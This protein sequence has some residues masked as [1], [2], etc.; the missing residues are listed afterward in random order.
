M[1]ALPLR[2]R[3]VGRDFQPI[4]DTSADLLRVPE[5]DDA[6]WAATAAPIDT[7]R[8]DPVFY[9]WLDT[10]NDGRVRS[11]ELRAA[12]RWTAGL[13]QDPSG[14]DQKSDVVRAAALKAD[15]PDTATLKV[16]ISRV[17]AEKGGSG[18]ASLANVR[19]VL[20]DELAKG[21]SAAGKILPAAAGDD[22]ELRE[23][24]EHVIEVTGGTPHPAG[25]PAVGQP[26]LDRFLAEAK[27]WL[28]WNEKGKLGPDGSSDVLP[29]GAG[30]GA[31][32]AA[33]D[34][35]AAKLA[36]Y[37][38]LCDAIALDAALADKARVDPTGTDL[39]DVG[40]ATALLERAPIA[41][42]RADGV[43]DLDGVVNPAWRARVEALRAAA[44]APAQLTRASFAALSAR[45]DAWRAHTASPPPAK[46]GERGEVVATEHSSDP[47]LV[48]RATALLEEATR[49]AGSVDG[50]KLLEKLCLFQANLLEFA[51][52]LVCMSVL[53]DPNAKA[54][55]E[56][57]RLVLDGKE[58]DMSF[59]VTDAGRAERFGGMSP[60]FL[61][62]VMVGEKGGAWTEQIVVPVTAG[63]RGYVTDGTWGVFFPV[64]GGEWHAQVRKIAVNPI[65]IYEALVAPFRRISD[66]MQSAADKAAGEQTSAMAGKVDA[67]GASAGS[68]VAGSAQSAVTTGEAR[69]LVAAEA[70][71]NPPPAAPPA[72]AAPA[73]PAA[74]PPPGGGMA[75]QL[76]LLL[77]G[78]GVAFAA[79][80]TALGYV[81]GLF[82]Q[83]A[84]AIAGAV[85]GL[86]ILNS[87]PAAAFT[88]I[89]V[90]SFPVA[91]L[92]M[93]LGVVLV[94]FLIYAIPVS[95]ATWLRLRRR[96]L[97]T[98]LEGSG[99]AMNRRMFLDRNLAVQLT[100]KP[101][102]PLTEIA[103][104]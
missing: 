19:A 51:N 14:L 68:A 88:V 58:F 96:D 56:R 92:L 62:Y 83:G 27:A 78:A 20:A 60:L 65:S 44:Q 79:V 70:A 4:V 81:V 47:T 11:D 13:L 15:G 12:I 85:T 42:P 54:L 98:V 41:A 64:G 37:F 76:P 22:A 97:S 57:G 87:L 100:K 95:F 43:F 99:W 7:L 25:S 36:Q 8:G 94:P 90:L 91:V 31:A 50:L 71:A 49:N 32:A 30:T 59:K 66:A 3:R 35:V 72:P 55:C 69:A 80:T 24:L 39:L 73:A 29:L 40:Q 23:F 75:G 84:T 16:A 61:M 103:K 26:E 46:V 18:D 101:T 77:A 93:L 86:P 63:E 10:D 34:A 1:A 104:R 53:Y 5:L 52:N 48:T 28:E 21:L 38:L 6:Y 82:M 9:K 17:N 89:Q 67:A 74:P 33:V 102:V 45:F 2:F